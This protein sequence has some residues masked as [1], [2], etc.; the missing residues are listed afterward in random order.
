MTLPF[1]SSPSASCCCC[2]YNGGRRRAHKG[3]P[4]ARPTKA[5]QHHKR[6]LS[7]LGF[8][9]CV[10]GIRGKRVSCLLLRPL[11]V[12]STSFLPASY[13]HPPTQ[14][15]RFFHPLFFPFDISDLP[16]PIQPPPAGGRFSFTSFWR[17]S[18]CFSL[19]NNPRHKTQKKKRNACTPSLLPC[20]CIPLPLPYALEKSQGRVQT[21]KTKSQK[22]V[23]RPV[24]SQSLLPFPTIL[25]TPQRTRQASGF[26]ARRPLP[27]S[28]RPRPRPPPPCRLLP[29]RPPPRPPW[30]P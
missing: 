30:S 7:R 19:N 15:S 9:S 3:Q 22:E 26:R 24:I 8:F 13:Y 18:S 5:P 29:L 17:G 1:L 23:G 21:A 20:V 25:P 4:R 14:S 10:E 16:L 28:S 2:C 11:L 6:R 27:S 12:R